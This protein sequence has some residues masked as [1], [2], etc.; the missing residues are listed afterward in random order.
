MTL[1]ML[2]PFYKKLFGNMKFR[3]ANSVWRISA[4]CLI[5]DFLG[6]KPNTWAFLT[7]SLSRIMKTKIDAVEEEIAINL[8]NGNSNDTIYFPE[9]TLNELP[10]K[11]LNAFI[12]E[13]DKY[14]MTYNGSCQ[15]ILRCKDFS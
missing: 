14:K 10:D 15:A 13:G 4:N 5:K 2:R 7:S 9:N 3:I 6:R 8:S 1:K 11:F 12:K